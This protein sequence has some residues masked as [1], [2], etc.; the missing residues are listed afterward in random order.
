MWQSVDTNAA[1]AVV[2]YLRRLEWRRKNQQGNDAAEDR[3]VSISDICKI[4]CLSHPKKCYKG[5]CMRFS[6][7][8]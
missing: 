1:A 7:P 6:L 3:D 2:V 5:V 4:I 8:Q